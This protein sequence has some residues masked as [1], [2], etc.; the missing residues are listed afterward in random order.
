M[1]ALSDSYQQ[2]ARVV[3]EKNMHEPGIEIVK[4]KREAAKELIAQESAELQAA[5]DAELEFARQFKIRAAEKIVNVLSKVYNEAQLAHTHKIVR[6]L[7]RH[8]RMPLLKKRSIYMRNRAIIKNYIR[9]CKRLNSLSASVHRYKDLRVAWVIFNRWIKLIEVSYLDTTPGL[10]T[11]IKRAVEL[12]KSYTLHLRDLGF[13][14]LVYP[15]SGS[16]L[17]ATLGYKQLFLRW[18]MYTQDNKIFRI[19]EE[20]AVIVYSVKLLRLCFNLLKYSRREYVLPF[21]PEVKKCPALVRATMDLDQIIKRFV[22]VRKVTLYARIGILNR[23]FLHQ[24]RA[25]AKRTMTFK[26]FIHKLN[27]DVNRRLATEMAVL[28]DAFEERGALRFLDNIY[29]NGVPSSMLALPG[30]QFSDPRLGIETP[31]VPGGYKMSTVNVCVQEGNG[32]IGWQILWSGDAAPD[33]NGPKRGKWSGA[34]IVIHEINIPVDDFVTDVEYY[35]EGIIIYGIRLHLFLRGW[36]A[37]AG[38]KNSLSTLSLLLSARDA[39]LP[40]ERNSYDNFDDDPD[41]AMTKRYIVGFT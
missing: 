30:N 13:K 10:V 32:V 21:V 35:Y 9:I 18:K 31:M 40:D 34:A 25:H 29:G 33:I 20:K 1:I 3:V 28:S 22:A 39:P 23:Q 14:V 41:T 17:P 11:R 7:F 24:M 16:L 12:Y 4:V 15:R 37:W 38:G 6:I 5:Q 19:A 2:H 8:L 27:D 26:G 36:T